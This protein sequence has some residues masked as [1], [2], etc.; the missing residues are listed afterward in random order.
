M[1]HSMKTWLSEGTI[2]NCTPVTGRGKA[3]TEKTGKNGVLSF[4]LSEKNSYVLYRYSI[5]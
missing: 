1:K 2:V 4:E 5:R 3:F